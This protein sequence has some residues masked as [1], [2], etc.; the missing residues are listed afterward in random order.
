MFFAHAIKTVD[1][2]SIIVTR[3]PIW[4]TFGFPNDDCG[5]HSAE[6]S[7]VAVF[8]ILKIYD[9]YDNKI[10]NYDATIKFIN[11]VF[12]KIDTRHTKNIKIR[13]SFFYIV[14]YVDRD[15]YII[16]I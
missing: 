3:V 8:L 13:M 12:I 2:G 5:N 16:Y 11:K 10:Y 6:K 9:D 14:S 1:A 4:S 15:E 7:K